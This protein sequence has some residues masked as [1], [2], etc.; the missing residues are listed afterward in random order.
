VTVAKEVVRLTGELR[1]SGAFARLLD[2]DRADL[3]RDV[4]IAL[5]RA[6]WDHLDR[7]ET[8]AIYQRAVSDPDWVVASRLADIPANRLTRMLDAR[9]SGL[10][11]RVIDRPEPEARIGLLRRAGG[12]AL[13]D[14]DRALLAACRARLRSILDDEVRAA[15]D[16]VLA[17]SS[18]EDMP[19]LG[20]AL[21]RLRADPR[22]LH[23]AA[24]R[25]CQY[26]V[27]SR[28]SWGR[29]AD[30]LAA[31]A[32]RDP[33]WSVLA[34]RAAASRRDA[35][36]LVAA[37]ESVPLDVDAAVAAQS[38]VALLRDEELEAAIAGLAGS[39]RPDV[40]RVAVS[41]LERDARPGRGW[42]PARLEMLARLR[43]DPSPEVAG[44]AA[45]VW[46]PREQDP[47]FPG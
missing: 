46:P 41:A 20:E 22:A 31:V 45:R 35:G 28:A 17:R 5:L 16:A 38:A 10:L 8:W 29:A 11:S 42:T 14:R 40:R 32:R 3:H 24:E 25:L 27:H 9:L 6:L 15:M 12:L 18:E 21:D 30:E 34:I 43:A 39:R 1:A 47:G 19:A 2:L 23:V 7:E 44:A 33:R 26:H 37:I 4:R 36:A 13:V